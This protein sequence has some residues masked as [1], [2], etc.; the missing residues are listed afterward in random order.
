MSPPEVERDTSFEFLI[1]IEVETVFTESRRMLPSCFALCLGNIAK[2][3]SP[4]TVQTTSPSVLFPNGPDDAP[5]HCSVLAPDV[6]A[7]SFTTLL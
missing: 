6:L 5:M 2:R 1:V 7:L 3:G 4:S